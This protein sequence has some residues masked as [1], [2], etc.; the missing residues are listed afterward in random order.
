MMRRAVTHPERTGGGGRAGV[1]HDVTVTTVPLRAERLV[2]GGDALAREASGRVVFVSGALPGELVNADIVEERR[3]YARAVATTVRV[4][5]PARRS[6]PCPF[7]AAGCGGCTWQHIDPAE[8]PELKRQL[9]LEALTRTG[10]LDDP[11]VVHG[12]PLTPWAFRTTVRMAVRHGRPGFRGA[13]RHDVVPVDQCAVAHPLLAE[14]LDGARYPGAEEV[15]LRVGAATG[16]RTA[17]VEP[18]SAEAGVSLPADVAVGR[19]ARLRE[20]VDGVVLR[21]SAR[22]FFQSRADGAAALVDTVRQAAGPLPPAV[23]DAYSGVGLFAATVAR[24]AE[25]T[26]IEASPVACRDAR[27]NLS[28]VR[29][30]V[31]EGAVE[32]WRPR[33]AGLVIA[34]PSRSG[35][36]RAAAACLAATGAARIVLVSCD[37]VSLARDARL[38]GDAGYDHR[39]STLV[40]LFPHTPHV[41]VV[42]QFDRR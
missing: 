5:S 41:E 22:S 31:V 8:Q 3:D 26:C 13:R 21:V 14:L 33:P 9:V 37:G 25:V 24:D 4:A 19:R 6:P 20:V 38:L 40:D 10:G 23:V 30:S 7:V 39:R 27:A 28:P 17:L 12:P 18:T 32:R 2:A 36:G 29:A 11:E 34:D 1:R 16:E 42:T 15:T 35:L